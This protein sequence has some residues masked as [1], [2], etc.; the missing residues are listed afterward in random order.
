MKT[1]NINSYILIQITEAGWQHL[2]STYSEEQIE[3][4][5]RR[6]KVFIAG[7]TWYRL[8]CHVVFDLF[9]KINLINSNILIEDNALTEYDDMTKELSSFSPDIQVMIKIN[10]N[11]Y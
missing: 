10:L 8:Q 1:F 5:V 9:N 6:K 2:R 3:T 11:S 4:R 7:D